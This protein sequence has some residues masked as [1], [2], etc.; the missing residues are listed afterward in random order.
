M[1]D[2]PPDRAAALV[3]IAIALGGCGPRATTLDES[4][5][6][7][8]LPLATPTSLVRTTPTNS[9]S[10][11][12]DRSDGQTDR[13]AIIALAD[14][15]F[16]DFLA[17][18]AFAVDSIEP[19]TMRDGREGRLVIVTLNPAVAPAAWPPG[20]AC[21]IAVEDPAITGIVWLID[22]DRDAILAVSPQWDGSVHCIV[23][24]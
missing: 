12:P 16:T 18:H 7:A 3:L 9:S 1:A 21:A 14:E 5:A 15:R 13:A 19:V 4:S 20:E 17:T 10:A 2:R 24:D 22:I 6:T 23:V 11:S 8:D